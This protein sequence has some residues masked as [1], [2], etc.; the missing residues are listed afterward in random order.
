MNV[1]KASLINGIIL[2]IMGLWG[3]FESSSPTAMIP[4]GIG[5]GIL[6]CNKGIKNHNKIIA[7]IAVLLTLLSFANI[8]P[9]N[10]ALN[11]DPL[12][13]NAVLRVSAMLLTSTIAMIYFIKSFIDARKNN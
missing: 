6:L 8:M 2:L 4:T 3:Y 5:I 7:H 9:L 1:H 11:D 10:S 12:R 13:L